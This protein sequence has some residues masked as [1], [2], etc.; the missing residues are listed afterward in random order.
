VKGETAFA[1][2]RIAQQ[3]QLAVLSHAGAEAV[4][5][6]ITDTTPLPMNATPIDEPVVGHGPFVINTQEEIEEAIADYRAGQLGR[7]QMD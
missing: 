5:E 3:G 4:I 1:G 7:I 6:A 2:K